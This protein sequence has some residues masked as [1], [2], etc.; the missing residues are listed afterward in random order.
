MLYAFYRADVQPLFAWLKV[1]PN[2]AITVL[3]TD[4]GIGV[5]DVGGDAQGSPGILEPSAIELLVETMHAAA[6]QSRKA[7]GAAAEN[8]DLYQI[9]CTYY[10]ALGQNDTEYL[11]ARAVQFF[12]PGIPQNDYTAC[13][14]ELT[15]WHCCNEAASVATS[16][17]TT[18]HRT[19]SHGPLQGSRP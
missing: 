7:T 1:R 3:D 18:I 14:R 12:V 9:N 2:N 19:G 8:L 6:D 15:I 4:D 17:A 11:I 16:I 10:D 13:R 5:I